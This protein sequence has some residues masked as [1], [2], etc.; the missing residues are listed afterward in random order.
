MKKL[1]QSTLVA[2]C[3][4]LLFAPT[5]SPAQGCY[6]GGVGYF[7]SGGYGY[8]RDRALLDLRFRVGARYDYGA[9]AWSYAPPARYY[10]PPAWYDNY[11]Q[12]GGAYGASGYDPYRNGYG[13][14]W[15]P[16]RA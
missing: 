8:G 11:G 16:G 12:R 14:A 6:G 3:L 2:P 5:P 9:P 10:A 7:Q 13:P 4:V 1:A 15:S